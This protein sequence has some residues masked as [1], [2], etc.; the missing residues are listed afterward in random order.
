MRPHFLNAILDVGSNRGAIHWM[1]GTYF[2]FY[3]LFFC[4]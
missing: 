4:C 2:K 1:G 3:F